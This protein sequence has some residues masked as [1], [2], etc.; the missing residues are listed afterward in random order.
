MRIERVARLLVLLIAIPLI[1]GAALNEQQRARIDEITG[2]KGAYTESEDVH[3]VTFPRSDLKVT[4]D[5]WT[6][7]PFMGLTSWAAFTSHGGH[8]MVMGDLTL[9]E[10]EVN[11]VMSVALEN[12]L[13]VTALHNHFFFDNPRIMFMHI[14]GAGDLEQLA[15]AVRKAV[16]KVREIRAA[17]PTP[18]SSFP[19]PSIA[20]TSSITPA[21]SRR[22]WASRA[23]HRA[24][25]TKSRS[26]GKRR[27]TGS[28]S[29][30]RWA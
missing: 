19:G 12:G 6:M 3:R 16:D 11:P 27:L 26:G 8:V 23:S 2:A 29:A 24:G 17:S 1:C 10:D 4:T 30:T 20:A 28:P 9:A 18:V 5:G 14:G 7:H 22:F 25:C 21:R 13:E 15:S